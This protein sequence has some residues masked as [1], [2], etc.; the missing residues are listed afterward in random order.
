MFAVTK[1]MQD[2]V[3]IKVMDDAGS[4]VQV[5]GNQSAIDAVCRFC[6]RRNTEYM[7][8]PKGNKVQIKNPKFKSEDLKAILDVNGFKTEFI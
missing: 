7:V 8:N 4:L 3:T 6:K 1:S 5:E 2:V